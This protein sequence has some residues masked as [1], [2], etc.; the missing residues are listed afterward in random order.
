MLVSSFFSI[1]HAH[2]RW[3][4]LPVFFPCPIGRVNK[5]ARPKNWARRGK[6]VQPWKGNIGKKMVN[7]DTAFGY[8]LASKS[9]FRTLSK[10]KMELFI[11]TT[12]RLNDWT[13]SKNIFGFN[14]FSSMVI[15]YWLLLLHKFFEKTLKLD[16]EIIITT[17]IITLHKKMKISIKNCVSKCH[18]IRS[19]FLWI[20]SHLLK[21]FL[22]VNFFYIVNN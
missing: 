19:R 17:I 21:K 4:C 8:L 22:M 1:K 7:K 18:Q 9:I 16:S 2:W 6:F 3:F 20:W 14:L 13:L 5:I 15:V 11:K 12:E 10:S